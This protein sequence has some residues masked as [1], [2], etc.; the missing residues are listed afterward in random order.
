MAKRQGGRREGAGRKREGEIPK[1]KT[2]ISIDADVL[3]EVR[4][5]A[6]VRGVSVSDLIEGWARD[7]L[8]HAHATTT[9]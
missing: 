9:E 7:G 4:R 3:D 2:S 5:L 6:A 8:E 1:V